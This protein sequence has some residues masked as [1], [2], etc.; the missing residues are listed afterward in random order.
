MNGLDARKWISAGYACH[1]FGGRTNAYIRPGYE[2][3]DD[4]STPVVDISSGTTVGFRYLQFGAT[5]P[6]S[7]TVVLGEARK[8][9]V[10][11]RTDSYRGRV[12][13]T[14]DFPGN[15]KELTAPLTAGVI[16]R[17]AVYFEFLSEDAEGVCSFDRFTFD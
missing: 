15:A 5:P 8:V 17:H 7:V 16:G 14:L 12:A 10:N 2:Q 3:R 13:A 6:K 1:I 9:R 11:V 4:I